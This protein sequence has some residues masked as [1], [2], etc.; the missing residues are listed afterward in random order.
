MCVKQH[1]AQASRCDN[2][3]LSNVMNSNKEFDLTA[4]LPIMVHVPGAGPQPC[5]TACC[6]TWR[7]QCIYLFE[8]LIP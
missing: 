8:H 2:A 5:F 4:S 1:T 6:Q 7:A 3:I